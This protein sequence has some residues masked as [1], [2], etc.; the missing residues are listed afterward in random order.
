MEKVRRLL[1][2]YKATMF[3]NHYKSQ[4]DTLKLIPAFYD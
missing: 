1:A 2:E 4:T 3:I